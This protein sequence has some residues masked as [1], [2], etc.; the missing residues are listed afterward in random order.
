MMPGD[1]LT[2]PGSLGT[3]AE[4]R[5]DDPGYVVGAPGNALV[6]E[7]LHLAA[8]GLQALAQVRLAD[9]PELRRL[10]GP[11]LRSH[12]VEQVDDHGLI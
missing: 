1:Q 2:P 6:L 8:G 11:A 7:G 5:L 12:G 10:H 9:H 3:P 4:R